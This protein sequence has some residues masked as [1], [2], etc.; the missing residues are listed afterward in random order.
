[1]RNTPS[2]NSQSALEKNP[3]ESTDVW[4]PRKL[5][6]LPKELQR[7]LKRLKELKRPQRG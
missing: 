4:A 3:L 2:P 1:M 5:Q 7:P 6:S